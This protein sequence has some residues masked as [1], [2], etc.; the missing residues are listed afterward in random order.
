M[1]LSGLSRTNGQPV[2]VSASRRRSLY[3][4]MQPVSHLMRRERART[5]LLLSVA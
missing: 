3:T 5:L 4:L 1:L 2:S